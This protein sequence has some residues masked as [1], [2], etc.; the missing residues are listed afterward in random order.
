MSE[1]IT[2]GNAEPETQTAETTNIS[3]KELANRRLGQLNQPV[4]EEPK[5]TEEEAPEAEAVEEQPE[6]TEEQSEENVLS[7]LDFD[8]LS[9]DELREISEKL[10]S[11]AVARYGELTARRKAAEE[12][13]ARLEA[14]LQEKKDP[15]NQPREIKDNP[16]SDLDTIEKLQEKSDEVNSAVEWAEELLF[17]SDGYA[18]DDVITEVDGKD[19]TKAEVRKALLNARKAQKQYLPDQL[20]KVQQREQ[21]QQL[22]AAFEEQA[23]KELSWLSGEDNDVRKSYE[24]TINDPRFNKLKSILDK[25]APDIGAQIEYW[26]AHATNSIYGRKP[27][28]QTKTSPSLN[29]TKTGTTTAAKSEKT[30]TRASKAMKDL[31]ARFRKSGT[32]R[33]FAELRKLQLQKR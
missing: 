16:F 11:R 1:E 26:F 28:E 6:A 10:G 22:K 19:I 21:G 27:V 30:D 17:E 13:V 8:N 23:T 20:N 2:T 15:L 29:P 4:E 9:E 33:D 31:Q 14:Q 18:A 24:A 32:A 7:Q 12:K 5:N 25:E 3:V